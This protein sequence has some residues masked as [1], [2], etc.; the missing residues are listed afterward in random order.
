M[1]GD[2]ADASLIFGVDLGSHIRLCDHG[3]T[4]PGPRGCCALDLIQALTAK[5]TPLK[6]PMNSESAHGYL[7]PSLRVGGQLHLKPDESVYL[8]LA[9]RKT[10]EQHLR[11]TEWGLEAMDSPL[12]L[13]GPVCPAMEIR[14]VAESGRK[15]GRTLEGAQQ[16]PMLTGS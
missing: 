11:G 15:D 7:H 14:P 13:M 16:G 6:I 1:S 4:V 8:G 2:H 5:A 9:L 12:Q 10:D 3:R